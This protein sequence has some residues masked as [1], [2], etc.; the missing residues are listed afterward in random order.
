MPEELAKTA[1]VEESK[2]AENG[3]PRVRVRKSLVFLG[4][5]LALVSWAYV[6][7]FV[8]KPEGRGPAGPAVPLEPFRSVW[9]DRPV[10]V[11]GVGDS[12]TAGFGASPGHAYLERLIDNPPTEF[13]DMAGRSLRH[14]FPNP[15]VR[16][17]AL[18]G[19]TSF[20]H[21]AQQVDTLEVQPEE[22]LGLIVLTTGGNDLI[23]NY[24]RTP[25]RP[26]AMY[27]ATLEQ[28]RPWFEAFRKRLDAIVGGLSA[29]FPGGCHIFLA[30]IYDPTDG[31]GDPES[32]G[33]PPWPD[34]V[35]IVAAYNR[36]IRECSRRHANV[37]LVDIHSQF[38][39][40]GIHCTQPWT[41]HY[42]R[43]D[44]HDW[45]N[46]NLEDPNDRGYD[47]IRRLMLLEL[48]RVRENL[49]GEVEPVAAG[50]P[51]ERTQEVKGAA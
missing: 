23:H 39:G 46:A 26:E 2:S 38:L 28:A 36:I 9:T 20:Q 31:A 32:I 4:I 42:R 33:L 48:L 34:S 16:S 7:F 12:I 3:R 14:V 13:D 22:V 25:P 18:S 40:H 44:P 51:R 27:G 30:N 15:K 35:E 24:G 5:G 45:Y 19:S 43:G 8:A 41:K 17:I 50:K 37:H 1:Q 21:L 47:A 10:L 49:W 6:Y 11:L 29:K